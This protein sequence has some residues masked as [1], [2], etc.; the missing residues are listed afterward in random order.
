LYTPDIA[1][2][3]AF[4]N[5]T[6]GLETSAV[7][8]PGGD[9]TCLNPAEGGED[10]MFGG[11]V[12]LDVDPT[13]APSGAYWLAYFEV[14]DVDATVAK[15]QETGGGVAVPAASMEGVGRMA[16][17]TDPHGARFAVIKSEPPQG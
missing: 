17:L 3:A 9:Y 7:P 16:Q 1:A 14:A 12:P 15:A 2:A 4:Y 10:A 5:A 13:G 11:V 8:F 6:L